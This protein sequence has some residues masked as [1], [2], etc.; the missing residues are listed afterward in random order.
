MND[1]F[2]LYVVVEDGKYVI[3]NVPHKKITPVN[4][5]E[6]VRTSKVEKQLSKI[7]KYMKE[8]EVHSFDFMDFKE[9]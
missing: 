1:V 8:N 4:D 7:Y 9:R 3:K 2:Y 5:N 6:Y